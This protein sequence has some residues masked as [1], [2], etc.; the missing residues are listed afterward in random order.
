MNLVPWGADAGYNFVRCLPQLAQKGQPK[1]RQSGHEARIICNR[2]R[3]TTSA[4]DTGEQVT[5]FGNGCTVSPEKKSQHLGRGKQRAGEEITKNTKKYKQMERQ[6]YVLET[7]DKDLDV[8]DKF[9]W[10]NELKT[11]YKPIPY[12][13]KGKTAKQ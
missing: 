7:I 12:A 8:R 11:P 13:Q 9:A 5:K 4:A 10:I 3:W 1:G 2:V 6:E